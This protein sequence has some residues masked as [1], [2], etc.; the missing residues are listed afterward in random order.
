MTYHD[1]VQW[2]RDL[3]EQIW[4]DRTQDWRGM[5]GRINQRVWSQ[6]KRE[7]SDE[8]RERLFAI[9]EKHELV[10][11]VHNACMGFGVGMAVYDTPQ[12]PGVEPRL[13]VDVTMKHLRDDMRFDEGWN[14]FFPFVSSEE[15]QRLMAYYGFQPLRDKSYYDY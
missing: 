14:V 12:Y 11:A 10:V 5:S 4:Q 1:D 8:E 15:N 7:L 6:E 3:H 13:C 2:L 9:I